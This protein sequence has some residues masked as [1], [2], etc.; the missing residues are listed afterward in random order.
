MN[1]GKST[2]LS[3]IIPLYNEEGNIPLVLEAF[4][5]MREKHEF[6]LIC[7][8][9]GSKDRSKEIFDNFAPNHPFA[10]MISYQPNRGYGAAIMEGVRAVQS[11]VIAWTHA[12]LQTDPEDVIR[13]F[14]L[15]QSGS[16]KR[17]VK[18]KRT[19]RT[20]GQWLLTFGMSTIAT[21][22]LGKKLVDINA[23]P[24]LFGRDFLEFLKDAPTDF[25]LDTYWL[26]QASTHRYEVLELP[27]TF[28]KRFH[29]VSK[30]APNFRGLLKTVWRTVKFLFRLRRML[31][32]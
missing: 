28:K 4:A 16:G 14:E 3:I 13:A 21:L 18:G 25:S 29:G 31:L 30:S 12:D 19:Q 1:I 6:E 7:V 17:V 32:R 24:K 10:R 22:V 15:Y 26:Y 8:D 20:F 23:Q 2:L 11:E 5:A 27:V 9:D